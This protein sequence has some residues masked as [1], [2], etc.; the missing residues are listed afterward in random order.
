MF[1]PNPSDS[2]AMLCPIAAALDC[3]CSTVNWATI[4]MK[5]YDA[6][7]FGRAGILSENRGR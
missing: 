4:V 2:Q 7:V 3:S 1:Y 6:V 5:V